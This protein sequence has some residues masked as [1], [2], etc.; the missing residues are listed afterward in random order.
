VGLFSGPEKH[1]FELSTR[2]HPLYFHYMYEKS[3]DV[4][5]ELPLGWQVS[6]VPQPVKKDAKVLVYTLQVEDDKG[7][8][9]LERSL[10][11]SL[12]MLEQKYYGALRNFY[13]AVRSADEQQ[14]VLQPLGL[15]SGK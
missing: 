6:S 14:I 3:D 7:T 9:H 5:V 12:T 15:S 4:R 2:V 1:M 8:L 10:N 13:Q 11:S